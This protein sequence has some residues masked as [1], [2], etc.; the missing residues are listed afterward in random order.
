GGRDRWYAD[1][2]AAF[3]AAEDGGARARA[4]ALAK[5]DQPWQLDPAT[6]VELYETDPGATRDFITRHLPAAARGQDWGPLLELARERGDE[7]FYFAVYRK[8][9]PPKRW[10]EDVLRLCDEVEDPGE[11]VAALEQRHPEGRLENAGEVFYRLA[12]KRQRD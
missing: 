4:R 10:R 7:V 5:Y 1:L 6:A 9:V 8:L 2:L 12:E 11:L 3:R